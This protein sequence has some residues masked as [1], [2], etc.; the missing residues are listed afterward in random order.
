ML[1]RSLGKRKALKAEIF[2]AFG[3][4]QANFNREHYN[5]PATIVSCEKSGGIDCSADVPLGPQAKDAGSCIFDLEAENQKVPV[6]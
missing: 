3:R 2:K 1:K 4:C 6:S 5:M